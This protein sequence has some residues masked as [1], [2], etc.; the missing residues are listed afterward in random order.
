MSLFICSKCGSVENT[1]LCNVDKNPTQY[2]VD[3]EDESKFYPNLS[4]F[5]M[6]GNSDPDE[7]VFVNGKIWKHCDQ[8]MPLCSECNTGTWHGQFTKYQAS[9][10]EK[11]VAQYSK[12]NMITPFDHEVGCLDTHGSGTITLNKNYDSIHGVFREVF[13]KEHADHISDFEDNFFRVVYQVFKEDQMNFKFNEFYHNVKWDNPLSVLDYIE[14]CL[15]YPE[16]STSRSY[17]FLKA[18]VSALGT[19]ARQTG[20]QSDMATLLA[21]MSALTGMGLEDFIPKNY[22][23]P[24]K[25]HWKKTQS[26]EDR[27]AKLATA[28]AKRDRKKTLNRELKKINKELDRRS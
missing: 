21:G 11:E 2:N 15:V 7:A 18:S 17:K 23:R 20:K 13:G 25:P 4:L 1:N 27:N 28:Q 8:I 3:I 10:E 26:E 16:E 22:G 19:H 9:K 14:K 5:D 12:Y 6:H 24:S